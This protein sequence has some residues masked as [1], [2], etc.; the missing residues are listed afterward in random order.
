M[1]LTVIKK[2]LSEQV[3]QIIKKAGYTYITDYKTGQESFVRRLSKEYYPRF[4]IYLHDEAERTVVNIHLDQKKASYPGAHA[5]NA[6]Y[7]GET[8]KNELDRI[9][10]FFRDSFR[11]LLDK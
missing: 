3:E 11:G 7:E 9:K 8:V 1:K 4:H 5:H 6:E 10:D 2:H